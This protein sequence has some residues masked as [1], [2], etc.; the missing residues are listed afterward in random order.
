MIVAVLIGM[1]VNNARLG[2]VRD[3]LGAQIQSV[4]DVMDAKFETVEAKMERNHSEMLHRFADLDT[5]LTR[6]ENNLGMNR[7]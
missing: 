2:D 7:G 6:L 3:S 5:R 4:R 1:L